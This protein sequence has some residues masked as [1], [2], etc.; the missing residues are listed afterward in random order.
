MAEAIAT[1]RYARQASRAARHALAKLSPRAKGCIEGAEETARM[2]DDDHVG[3]EHIVLGLID[4]APEVVS[5][6]SELGITR[7]V[8]EAQLLDESG[9]SPDGPIPSTPRARKALGFALREARDLHSH[10]VEPPH[11]LLGVI[12]ESEYWRSLRPDGPHHLE[13][14]LEAV[15]SSLAE[16]RAAVLGSIEVG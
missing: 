10:S 4:G 9:V 8:F 2:R 3:T 13:Q 7:G 11:V 1:R 6:L 16:L 14:A 5:V 12:D 15:G